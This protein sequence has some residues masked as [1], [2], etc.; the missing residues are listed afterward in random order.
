MAL[1]RSLGLVQSGQT[2]TVEVV[3]FDDGWYLND[4][5]HNSSNTNNFTGINSPAYLNSFSAFGLSTLSG[6][7]VLS[8]KISFIGDGLYESDGASET[9]G[10][11]DVKTLIT[12]LVAGGSG[13]VGTFNDLG[14]GVSYG[15]YVYTATNGSPT[16]PFSVALNAFALA[17]IH[18]VLAGSDTRFAIGATLLSLGSNP[19]SE[20]AL[21]FASDNSSSGAAGLTLETGVAPVPLPTSS[22]LLVASLLGLGAVARRVRPT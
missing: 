12:D 10:L 5:L 18:T 21:W 16:A 8:A 1:G 13:L 11:F 19:T 14:S 4:G 6:A 9:L 20:E 22:F 15:R 2:A 3:A 17:D 7:N